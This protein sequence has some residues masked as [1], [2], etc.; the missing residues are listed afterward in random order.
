MNDFTNTLMGGGV[1]II[2]FIFIVFLFL[3]LVLWFFMPFAVFGTKKILLEL[4][5]VQA[6]QLDKLAEIN[7][8]QLKIFNEIREHLEVQEPTPNDFEGPDPSS[9]I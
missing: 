6:T 1:G 4:L 2:G 9:R 3:T 5:E 7:L 8:V